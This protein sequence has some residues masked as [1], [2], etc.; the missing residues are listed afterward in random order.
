VRSIFKLSQVNRR[1]PLG[2]LDGD[3]LVIKASDDGFNVP[4]NSQ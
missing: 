4:V 1:P 2:P 3:L